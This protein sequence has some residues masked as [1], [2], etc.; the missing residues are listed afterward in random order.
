MQRSYSEFLDNKKSILFIYSTYG[1]CSVSIMSGLTEFYS[2]HVALKEGIVN[3]MQG[4]VV[5][6]FTLVSLVIIVVMTN[7][8]AIALFK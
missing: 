6:A 5:R 7:I 2:A 8:L 3:T 4:K 1:Y